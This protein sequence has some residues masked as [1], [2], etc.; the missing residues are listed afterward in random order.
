MLRE[1]HQVRQENTGRRRW[2]ED[3]DLELV[4]WF[5]AADITGFQLLYWPEDG[6]RALTW[7]PGTGFNHSK[8]DTGSLS[9]FSGAGDLTPILIP[10]GVVPWDRVEEL[11]RARS[12]T[13][14]VPL[15]ELVLARLGERR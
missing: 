10:D 4:V 1:Y 8:V 9:P 3:N 12:E 13:L 15:R 14:E 5:A 2:F 7:R 11:F 6:E